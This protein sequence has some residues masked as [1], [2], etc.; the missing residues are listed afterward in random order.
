M[1]RRKALARRQSHPPLRPFNACSP[2]APASVTRTPYSAEPITPL[3]DVI[4]YTYD[5]R[6]NSRSSSQSPV[7][8]RLGTQCG[9]LR[10]E[11]PFASRGQRS[12]LCS[13]PR[14]FSPRAR[15]FH[16]RAHDGWESMISTP[17]A[18][19]ERELHGANVPGMSS[20]QVHAQPGRAAPSSRS[21]HHALPPLGKR[22]GLVQN[23]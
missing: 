4:L 5:T 23:Y 20:N 12:K 10:C 7:R 1:F 8:A 6:P 15:A 11:T 21:P 19:P 2:P 3:A 22:K 16:R 13:K 9:K 18:A 14:E 17:R